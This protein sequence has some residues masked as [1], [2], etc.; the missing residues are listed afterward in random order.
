MDHISNR[1]ELRWGIA[2]RIHTCDTPSLYPYAPV[3]RAPTP[4]SPVPEPGRR[5]LGDIPLPPWVQALLVQRLPA[6]FQRSDPYPAPPEQAVMCVLDS[7][8]LPVVPVVCVATHGPGGG[9]PE[10]DQLSLVLVAAEYGRVLRNRS[11]VSEHG[12][13]RMTSTTPR[14]AKGKR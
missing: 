3:D 6:D 4:M 5:S 10:P 7:G 2:Q 8:D 9:G 1:Q 14:A 13:S 12:G 11:P